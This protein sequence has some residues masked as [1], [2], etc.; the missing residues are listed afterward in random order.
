L[1]DFLQKLVQDAERRVQ[2]GYYDLEDKTE[3]QPISMSRKI[4]KTQ[5]NAIIAEIKRI[6]PALGSLKPELD[7]VST[8][9]KLEAGG[10]AGLSVLTEPDNFGGSIQSLLRIRPHTH[11]PILMKDIVI[12]RKQILAARNCGADCILLIQSIFT[13]LKPSTK[14][15]ELMNT[16]RE[17][18]LETLLEVH[19]ENE[20]KNALA[21]SAE[22]VGINNRNLSTLKIDLETTT[23]LLKGLEST[24]KVI[25]SE[26]GLENAEDLRKLKGASVDAFL[27]GSS[28]MLS[29]NLE[30]KV[31][32]FALA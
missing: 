28:I 23:R 10:A 12:D 8:A 32:E 14:L 1:P 7:P 6:S 24:G 29:E 27:I 4:M 17:Q 22:M 5:R 15:G 11:L 31:R 9:I 16:A 20:L 3:H 18:D 30:Q 19:D 21:T 2:A 13:N 25:I 26:S